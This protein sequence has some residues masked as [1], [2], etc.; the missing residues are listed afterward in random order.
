MIESSGFSI[1]PLN[2]TILE[3]NQACREK[4][5]NIVQVGLWL[6]SSKPNYNLF[7]EKALEQLRV[8]K[9]KVI[10]I[11]NYEVKIRCHLCLVDL[12]A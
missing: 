9:D 2:G 12:P 7:Y 1:W 4:F 8:Y 5:D 3:L 10:K 11:C 6:H